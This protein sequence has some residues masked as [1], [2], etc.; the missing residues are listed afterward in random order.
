MESEIGVVTSSSRAFA[1]AVVDVM[2]ALEQDIEPVIEVMRSTAAQLRAV[3]NVADVYGEYLGLR[4]SV[5]IV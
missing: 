2:I 1:Y 3:G 4:A 5:S